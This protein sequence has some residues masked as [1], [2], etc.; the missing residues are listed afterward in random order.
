MNF[1]AV[2]IVPFRIDP[3]FEIDE[4][5]KI[6]Q[7]DPDILYFIDNFRVKQFALFL[8]D[9]LTIFGLSTED[10]ISPFVVLL[11]KLFRRISIVLLIEL[12]IHSDPFSKIGQQIV[13]HAARFVSND[14]TVVQRFGHRYHRIYP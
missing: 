2:N 3:K 12:K 4:L 7:P 6:I 5:A 1:R 11:N 9:P 8:P 14:K 13:W 10:N